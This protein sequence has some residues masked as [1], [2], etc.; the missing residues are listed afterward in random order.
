MKDMA[1][2]GWTDDSGENLFSD[3][4]IEGVRLTLLLDASRLS[5]INVDSI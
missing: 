2:T 5:R 1:T 3:L 4:F